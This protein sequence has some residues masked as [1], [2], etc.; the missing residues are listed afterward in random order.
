MSTEQS[1]AAERINASLIEAGKAH[2]KGDLNRAKQ[3]YRELLRYGDHPLLRYNLGLIHYDLREYGEAI[4]S[5]KAG[6][7]MAP[8]D[9]DMRFNLALS[10]GCE[11][12]SRN[13]KATYL[14]IVEVEPDHRDANYNLANLYR[15]EQQFEQA[16]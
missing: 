13:S 15:S 4:K 8:E 14:E 3:L 12:D 1:S 10:F 6:L 5:F 9:L 7:A 2:E 11:G 16:T